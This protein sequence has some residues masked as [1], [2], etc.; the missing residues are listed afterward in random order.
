M[1]VWAQLQ[2]DL[3]VSFTEENPEGLHHPSIQFVEVPSI[4]SDLNFTALVFK[5]DELQPI[6]MEMFDNALFDRLKTTR[7]S[8]I[9]LGTVVY[10][11][12]N[13][14]TSKSNFDTLTSKYTTGKIQDES[15]TK[16]GSAYS[17]SIKTQTGYLNMTVKDLGAVIA[18]I[19]KFTND[20]FEE[21]QTAR[22]AITKTK[23]I[24]EKVKLSEPTS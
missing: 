21:E 3:V 19:D 24:K 1:T 4:Y 10:K 16:K 14:E 5:D 7:K 8:K 20:I 17:V 13:F 11:D 22:E 18:L 12:Q 9:D 2:N 6:S 23:D 15:S